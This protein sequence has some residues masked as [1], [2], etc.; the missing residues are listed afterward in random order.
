MI[1]SIL[2]SAILVGLGMIHFNWA[3]GGT[4]GFAESIPTK[5]NGQR[6][7][8]PKKID[9]VMVAMGLTLFGMFYLLKSILLVLNLPQWLLKYG[10]W[11]I[12]KLFLLRASGDFK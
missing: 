8:N 10:S 2:L 4:F 7:L 1:L 9:S 5:E 3:I 12:P 11:V 6:V